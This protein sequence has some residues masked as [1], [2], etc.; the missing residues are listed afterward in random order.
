MKQGEKREK[1]GTK[2]GGNLAATKGQNGPI[3][4]FVPVD[5]GAA[6][7]GGKRAYLRRTDREAEFNMAKLFRDMKNPRIGFGV[8]NENNC[9]IGRRK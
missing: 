6:K 2:Q 5:K 9:Q 8:Y 7:S 1:T 3:H 4:S